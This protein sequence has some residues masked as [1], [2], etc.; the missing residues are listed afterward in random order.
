MGEAA[1][2]LIST[3]GYVNAGTIEFIYDETEERFY[4]IEM[5]TRIQVEHPVTEMLTGTDLVVEQ[6]RVAAGDRLSFG[7]C[8][9]NGRSAIEFRIN[10]EDPANGFRPTPGILT[11]WRPPSGPGIR[12]DS[13]V[14]EGYSVPP[15][16]DSL[17]GKL[18]VS[19]E[20][21]AVAIETAR[22]ALDSFEVSGISTTIAFHRR[23]LRRPE[24]AAGQV[25][26]RWVEH[27]RIMEQ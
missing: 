2:A 3:L 21:R 27:A 4:F 17:L 5:N 14:Y 13:H 7:S 15:F 24:F 12:F 25:H 18:I 11:R 10:A 23:L 20:T 6:F 1:V 19:G 16:Y 26:T 9:W 8:R 22:F